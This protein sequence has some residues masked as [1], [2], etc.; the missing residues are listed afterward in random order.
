MIWRGVF[1]ALF[2]V[3]AA[4]FGATSVFSEEGIDI[5]LGAGFG[6]GLNW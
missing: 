6:A 5:S 1:G 2:F 4:G 3:A